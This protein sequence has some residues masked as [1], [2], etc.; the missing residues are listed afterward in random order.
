MDL[1]APLV[2]VSW[3]VV[4]NTSTFGVFFT[5]WKQLATY[6]QSLKNKLLNQIPFFSQ[7]DYTACLFS[8]IIVRVY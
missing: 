3:T 2:A 8:L 4:Y 1:R 7:L 6:N 5:I